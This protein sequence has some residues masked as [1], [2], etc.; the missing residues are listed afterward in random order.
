MTRVPVHPGVRCGRS[1]CAAAVVL[2]VL[3]ITACSSGP[4]DDTASGQVRVVA[5]TNVYAQVAA[6]I[7]GPSGRVDAIIADAHTDPHSYVG[8]ARDVLALR[9]AD[10]VIVNGG[11]YDD[12]MEPLLHAADVPP[13]R[14]I[15][16]VDLARTDAGTA[17]ADNEHVFFDP[18][19]MGRVVD[20]LAALLTE[21]DPGD[22]D[23][24]AR[25][26]AALEEAFGDLLA[27]QDR[28]ASTHAGASVLVTDP[29]PLIL[30]DGCGLEDRTPSAFAAAI[31]DGT[32]VSP[33]LFDEVLEL[34]R[35]R[36]VQ[37]VVVNPGVADAQVD[38]VVTAS[39]AAHLPV[40]EIGEILPVGTTY[41][42]WMRQNL[43][44]LSSALGSG[45]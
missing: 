28:I 7:A 32:G 24:Y 34:V 15:D 25:R 1:A 18:T 20:R 14:V 45:S 3:A 9:N 8:N 2:V 4:D 5:S 16:A 36:R 12:F 10:V 6:Q 13:D 37:V 40:V 42:A 43:D 39:R 33:R 21:T 19:V 26:A 29:A 31:E 30:I 11:G 17:T 38:R 22:A 23:A 27:L 41:V 44:D 35:T